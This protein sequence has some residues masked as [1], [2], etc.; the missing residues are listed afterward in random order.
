MKS[1]HFGKSKSDIYRWKVEM[2]FSFVFCG[3]IFAGNPPSKRADDSLNGTIFA[4][5]INC[6][7]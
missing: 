6:R 5:S 2:D 1:I 3:S 7:T 4:E